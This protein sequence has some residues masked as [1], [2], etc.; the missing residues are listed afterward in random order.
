VVIE[1]RKAAGRR[2]A[3]DPSCFYHDTEMRRR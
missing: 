2:L 3:A 1:G